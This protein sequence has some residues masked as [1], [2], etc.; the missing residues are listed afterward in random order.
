MGIG[1]VR[2]IRSVALDH[3]AI[4]KFSV[5]RED[6][7]QLPELFVLATL[8]THPSH[9]QRGREDAGRLHHQE[10]I[11]HTE[12]DEHRRAGGADRPKHAERA[13]VLVLALQRGLEIGAGALLLR[14][15]LGG[16]AG[17]FGELTGEAL[18]QAVELV[19]TWHKSVDSLS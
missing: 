14:H 7:A 8:G 15:A 6:V 17:R 5:R 16:P 9:V 2:A 10:V 13:D 12:N 19:P 18:R 11:S 4:D 3:V 1:G